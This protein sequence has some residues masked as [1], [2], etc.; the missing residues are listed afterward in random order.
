MA[1]NLMLHWGRLE[2]CEYHN[3]YIYIATSCFIFPCT[4]VLFV[5]FVKD[6]E[7][8]AIYIS[9]GTRPVT[10]NLESVLFRLHMAH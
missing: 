5:Y 7:Y 6:E 2:S 9:F 10:F 3:E 4:L 1:S 8:L